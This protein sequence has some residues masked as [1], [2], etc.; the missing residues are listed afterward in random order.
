M[1]FEYDTLSEPHITRNQEIRSK[2][3]NVSLASCSANGRGPLRPTA[4]RQRHS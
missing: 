3:P 4:P 1:E 2:L